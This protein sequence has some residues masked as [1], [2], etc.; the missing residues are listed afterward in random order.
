MVIENR[1]A[2]SIRASRLNRSDVRD[3]LKGG[4]VNSVFEGRLAGGMDDRGFAPE[5]PVKGGIALDEPGFAIRTDCD[6][7]NRQH[8]RYLLLSGVEVEGV[9]FEVCEIYKFEDGD[10]A[11]W[12]AYAGGH[13]G[14]EGFAP[15]GDAEAPFVAGFEAGEAEF[16]GRGGEVVA[17]EPGEGEECVGE[18]DADGVEADVAGAGAAVA[19][20]VEASQRTQAA[21]LEGT[22][23]DVGLRG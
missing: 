6:K 10:V 19:V 23:Q 20:A 1:C 14:D 11:G 5:T 9:L 7:V 16:R 21:T 17:A 15:A 18:L 4:R 12:E 3:W 13:A 8:S 2:L 22:A